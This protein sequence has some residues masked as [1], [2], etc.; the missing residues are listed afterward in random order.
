MAEKLIETIS[1]PRQLF[2]DTLAVDSAE[3]EEVAAPTDLT[4]SVNSPIMRSASGSTLASTNTNDN[5]R[6]KS[7]RQGR[8]YRLRPTVKQY[9]WGIR[10]ADSRVARFALES[11]TIESIDLSAP[12]AELWIGTH[13][14]GP[15]KLD[16]GTALAL[17]VESADG[18]LPWLLKVLS[19]G[20]ALSIQAHPDKTTAAQLHLS[21]PEQYKD[22]NHKPEMAIALTP[23]EA[24]CGFRRLSEIAVNLRRHREFAN[25]IDVQAQLQVFT[26]S[27]VDEK[28]QRE[29]LMAL[30][31]SFMSCDPEVS[32]VQLAALIKK[33]RSEQSKSMRASGAKHINPPNND[34]SG[35][36]SESP[37]ERKAARAVLRL[38][39]Q[40]PGDAGAMAPLFLNYLLIAPGESFFMAA[41]EPHAYVA[42]EILEC[43]ACSDNVVRAGLTPKHKD[44][45]NLVDMLTYTMGGPDIEFGILEHQVPGTHTLRYTPPVPEFEVLITTVEPGYSYTMEPIQ[46]PSVLLCVE[47]MGSTKSAPGPDGEE[48]LRAHEY[49]LK[50]GISLFLTPSSISLV[51][52]CHESFNG[53]LRVARARQNLHFTL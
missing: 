20:K 22:S 41:N 16:D 48:P 5:L 7:K 17:V 14:S 42:G 47:G 24:M 34:V 46:V 27:P 1:N 21:N 36:Y 50:P 38:A 28:E 33:L 32:K 15:S 39:E 6:E 12:Y 8:V 30:F 43:M 31:Q 18:Q 13:P 26:A 19:A 25:C 51:L 29:A 40:F 44:V 37:W 23:F 53:P 11:G 10:G 49:D 35:V 9:A 4:D 3:K 2:S 52:S 45:Q